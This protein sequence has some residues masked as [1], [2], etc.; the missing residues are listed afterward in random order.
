MP[1]TYRRGKEATGTDEILVLAHDDEVTVF[2]SHS[3]GGKARW[4][5]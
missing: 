4:I 1:G 2:D 3:K 5:S